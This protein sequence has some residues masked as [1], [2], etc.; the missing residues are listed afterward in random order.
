MSPG[1][2]FANK[3][4]LILCAAFLWSML[5]VIACTILTPSQLLLSL[6]PEIMA[7]ALFNC[8]VFALTWFLISTI[9][10]CMDHDADHPIAE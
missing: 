1:K 10:T 3:L 7:I 4:V 9:A 5:N 6:M 2:Q 8:T